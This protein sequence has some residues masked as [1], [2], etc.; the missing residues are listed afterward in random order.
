M[1]LP[2]LACCERCSA[3]GHGAP[4]GLRAWW[5]HWEVPARPGSVEKGF[6]TSR[7]CFNLSTHSLHCKTFCT[8]LAR[9]TLPCR[10][11]RAW[12]PS[13]CPCLALPWGQQGQPRPG[14]CAQHGWEE[15]A[16]CRGSSS[17][18]WA[19]LAEEGAAELEVQPWPRS[20]SWPAAWESVLRGAQRCRGG[21]AQGFRV[22]CRCS[23]RDCC[24]P[25][26]F[27]CKSSS[28]FFLFSLFFFPH[29]PHCIPAFSKGSKQAEKDLGLCLRLL[30]GHHPR[31][32]DL[33]ARVCGSRTL[34]SDLR[35]SHIQSLL[36]LGSETGG[37][38]PI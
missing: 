35:E 1:P 5:R 12:L 36:S 13:C 9:A 21:V 18:G 6:E 11:D 8:A 29:K 23:H 30:L 16:P 26:F 20:S 22:S 38:E 24:I 31:R 34:S 33:Q 37:S 27:L 14:V 28:F 2:G 10:T 15:P 7:N 25:L 4:A 17:W 3:D 19:G 32:W